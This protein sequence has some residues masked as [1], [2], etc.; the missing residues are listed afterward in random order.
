M[1][2]GARR[3]RAAREDLVSRFPMDVG[4]AGHVEVLRKAVRG[5]L[6][7]SAILK[8]AAGDGIL[9]KSQIDFRKGRSATME[10]V[11]SLHRR[12]LVSSDSRGN[13]YVPSVR[14]QEVRDALKRYDASVKRVV[15]SVRGPEITN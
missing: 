14:S 3:S 2:I 6:G 15:D 10:Y 13:F 11:R 9:G 4:S 5:S 1:A 12:G 7:S 8:I